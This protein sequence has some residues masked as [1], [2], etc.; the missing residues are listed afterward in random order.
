MHTVTVT[1]SFKDGEDWHDSTSFAR[2]EIL[3]ASKALIEAH[4]WIDRE[5]AKSPR[6]ERSPRDDE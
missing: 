5:M 3:L 6:E 1:R 4:S 2:D